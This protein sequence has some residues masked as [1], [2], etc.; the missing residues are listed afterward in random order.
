[1]LPHPQTSQVSQSE[2]TKYFSKHPSERLGGWQN[3]APARGLPDLFGYAPIAYI[4][5]MTVPTIILA[6]AQVLPCVSCATPDS[7]SFVCESEGFGTARQRM[8]LE[9]CSA[10]RLSR[11]TCSPPHALKTW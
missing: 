7:D 1:V 3:V 5:N 8:A 9:R 10:P 4:N 11:R 2:L 6:M